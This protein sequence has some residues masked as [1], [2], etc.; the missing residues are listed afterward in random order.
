MAS[1]L[2][3]NLIQ[4]ILPVFIFIF[5]FTIFFALLNKIKMFG[6]NKPL[7][8]LIA[9]V[10]SILFVLIPEARQIIEIAT[11]WFVIFVVMGLLLIMCFMIL[12]IKPEFIEEVAKEN[13]VVLSVVVAA[14]VIIFLFSFTKIFG[15][16]I[17]QYP[18]QQATGLISIIKR[19]IL[20]PKIFG[21]VIVLIIAGE[22]VRRV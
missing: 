1:I 16:G 17:I 5:I 12:G 4:F 20:N 21:L 18:D 13:S 6:D 7:N 10:I 9:F 14:V 19:T 22:V 2:S 8:S 15:P 3:T 11:P